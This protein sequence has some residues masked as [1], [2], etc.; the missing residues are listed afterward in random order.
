M[1]EET[2][3]LLQALATAG[4]HIDE[5]LKQVKYLESQNASLRQS[6]N[7]ACSQAA[8]RQKDFNSL[9]QEVVRLREFYLKFVSGEGVVAQEENK[10]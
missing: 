7:A 2:A 9:E 8:L 5:L 6:Y 10:R 3:E 4:K 1:E